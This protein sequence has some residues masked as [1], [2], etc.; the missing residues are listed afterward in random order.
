MQEVDLYPPLKRFLTQQGYEV[1]GEVHNCDV[2]AVRGDEPIV[3]VELK[4]SINL[5]VVL[6]AVDRLRISNIVYIGVPKGIVVL[7]KQR[8]QIV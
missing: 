4:L 8:K 3:V 1:K 6:Q 7:K 2:I 5:T